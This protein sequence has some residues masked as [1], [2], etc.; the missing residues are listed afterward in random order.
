MRGLEGRQC[1]VALGP[2][3]PTPGSGFELFF[4]WQ[5]MNRRE[6]YKRISGVL[7]PRQLQ[8]RKVAVIGLGSGGCRVAAELARLGVQL[9]LVERPGE[10]LEEH[11]IVRHLLGYESLG[12]LK[13]DGMRNY[14]RNLNP[15]VRLTSWSLDVTA[16]AGLLEKRLARWRPDLVAVCTD[17]EQSKHAINQVALRLGI[18]QVGAG[19]YDGGIGGEVYRVTAG[20]ACYGCIAEQLQ[21]HRYTS[22]EPSPD[23]NSLP[24]ETVRSTC[25]LNLDIE[26]IA[27]LQSRL[28]LDLLLGD[29]S[30]FLGLGPEVNLCVFAN[31]VVPGT[32]A[33][34]LHGEFFSVARRQDC[35]DCGEPAGN[36]EA[37]AGRIL[38]ALAAA[39]GRDL[40]PQK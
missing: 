17:N 5:V 10:R 27:L 2:S 12:K 11:N 26:Q 19:V 20:R 16:Q 7:N 38:A 14:L 3:A 36:I 35:L 30:G 22:E 8:T 21:L 33:R 24:T 39:P 29:N 28:A 15:S 23:Y 32:F 31:R 1:R 37:E 13:L 40:A 4:N 9:L 18:P 6:F 34:P 25:A